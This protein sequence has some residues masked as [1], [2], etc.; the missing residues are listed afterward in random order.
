[1]N[2]MV[3]ENTSSAEISNLIAE[4]EKEL[5]HQINAKG[6]VTGRLFKLSR[7]ILE[8]EI[9]KK[10]LNMALSKA[11]DNIRTLELDISMLKSQFWK[12]RNSGL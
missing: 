9:A 4:K 1:M 5:Q 6:E 12:A 11:R 10:D 8:H 7:H 3:D 2:S